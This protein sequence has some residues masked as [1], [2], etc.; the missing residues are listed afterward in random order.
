MLNEV[1][2][3]DEY[4]EMLCQPAAHNCDVFKRFAAK[5]E[6]PFNPPVIIQPEATN[7]YFRRGTL[8]PCEYHY[9]DDADK[10]RPTL[11]NF[12]NRKLVGEDSTDDEFEDQ[13]KPAAKKTDEVAPATPENMKAL[14]AALIKE[15]DKKLSSNKKSKKAKKPDSSDDDSDGSVKTLTMGDFSDCTDN[16]DNGNFEDSDDENQPNKKLRYTNSNR[17]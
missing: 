4:F 14:A 15:Y 6:D 8:P 9:P 1:K 13:K 10:N 3:E 17:N 2:H 12:A 11:S 16:E 5:V 7:G